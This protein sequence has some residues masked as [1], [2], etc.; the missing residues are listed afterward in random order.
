MPAAIEKREDDYKFSGSESKAV[1]G[2]FVLV[3][4]KSDA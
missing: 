2:D 1:R 4:S 3:I